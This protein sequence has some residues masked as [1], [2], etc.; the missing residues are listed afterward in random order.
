MASRSAP[1]QTPVEVL[2]ELLG[3]PTDAD[4]APIRPRPGDRRRT[5]PPRV[6]APVPA[7]A[8]AIGG[9]A[10]SVFLVALG[11]MVLLLLDSAPES[12]TSEQAAAP[13]V[14]APV[15]PVP[16]SPSPSPLLAAA[17]PAA[18]GPAAEGSG[19]GL[20]AAAAPG[21]SVRPRSS[22]PAA[23]APPSPPLVVPV[24][25]LNN[26]RRTGLAAR[27]SAGGWPIAAVGNFRGRI[28]VTTVYYDPGLEASA[29]A[30]AGTFD[31]VVRV[32]PRFPTLPARGV[33]VVLTRE[34]A[35]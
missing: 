9:A 18:P 31:G 6:S 14:T 16:P 12:V 2:G 19:A 30:F 28:P 33:V 32:R 23:S 29:R 34:F 35:V 3:P 27:F 15:A 21:A 1:E 13:A 26:S 8:Q 22:A 17:P 24:T 11:V 10:V 5:P 25:V 4:L 20:P 7:V